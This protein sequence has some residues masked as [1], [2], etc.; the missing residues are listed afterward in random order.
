MSTGGGPIAT[1]MLLTTERA[2]FRIPATLLGT[3]TEGSRCR[4]AWDE[5]FIH[6]L[7]R[8]VDWVHD[9]EPSWSDRCYF[10]VHALRGVAA[11]HHWLR[12]QPEHPERG[13]VREGGAGRRPALDV[14][15]GRRC[16]DDRASSTGPMRWTCVEPLERWTIE[17]G[18]NDSGVE[19]ELHYESRARCGSCCR[20]RSARPHDRRHVPHQAAGPVHRLGQHR[21][22][23]HL[24]RRLPRR[25]RPHVLV[26]CAECRLGCG[27]KPAS[28]TGRSRR[29]GVGRG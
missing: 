4:T 17:L 25:P 14:D 18:P 9:A 8:P 20:S 22:R 28:T 26:R 27:S 3:S 21:G 23:A 19:Y 29:G 15:A 7:P 16:V 12:E 5:Y 11:R 2:L 10:N 1:C 13:R 6:Q 24:R